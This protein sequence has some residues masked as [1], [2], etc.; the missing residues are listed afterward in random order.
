MQTPLFEDLK[1]MRE[2]IDA[3]PIAFL[4]KD[5]A[6]CFLSMNSFSCGTKLVAV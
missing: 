6:S 4:V 2:L 5:G 3:M 1:I